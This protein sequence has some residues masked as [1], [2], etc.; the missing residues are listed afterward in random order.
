MIHHMAQKFS[1]EFNYT[2]L[3]LVVDHKIKIHKLDENLLYIIMTLRT[4]LGF[5]KTKIPST[6]HPN[7]LE[8]N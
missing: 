3:Q 4:N 7:D 5:R 6:V 2:V 1:M 8:A